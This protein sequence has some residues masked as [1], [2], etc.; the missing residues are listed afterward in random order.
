MRNQHALDVA[1][2]LSTTHELQRV[3]QELTMTYDAKNH[4]LNH[5]DDATKIYEI[6]VEKTKILSAKVMRLKSLLN[7]KVET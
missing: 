6:H 3:K 1:T 2:L 4:A 7:A 5:V